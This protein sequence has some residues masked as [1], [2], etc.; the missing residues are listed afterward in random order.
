M[1]LVPTLAL[2][3]AVAAGCASSAAPIPPP[4]LSRGAAGGALHEPAA[5]IRLERA[6]SVTGDI[7]FVSEGGG[8]LGPTVVYLVR[9]SPGAA[10]IREARPITI[11]SATLAFAPG[12]AGVPAGRPVVFDNRGPLAHRLFAAPLGTEAAIE[13]PP[14]SRSRAVS[15]P[16]EGPLT[17][18]CSLHPDETF[19]VFSARATHM[20]VIEGGDVYRF[21][22]VAPGRYSLRIWNPAVEGSVRDIVVDGLTSNV[23]RIW[24]DP[25]LVEGP[26]GE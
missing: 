9:R 17:F 24:L 14:E 18:F 26:P 4:P 13:V 6:S 10:G 11:E 21:E 19:T 7:R 2:A 8:T 5:P 25:K 23:E 16:P 3:S 22:G 12:L 20:T 15:L 1:R